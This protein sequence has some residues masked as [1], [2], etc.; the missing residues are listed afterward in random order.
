MIPFV[1]YWYFVDAYPREWSIEKKG[2]VSKELLDK[3]VIKN[4]SAS[5]S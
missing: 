5:I 4:I 2:D 3:K 1:L